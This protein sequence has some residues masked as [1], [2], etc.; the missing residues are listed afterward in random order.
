LHSISA[1]SVVLPSVCL[2]YVIRY[3]TKR[4]FQEINV[5]FLLQ[6]LSILCT[7]ASLYA[8]Y[9]LL[10]ISNK[11]WMGEGGE[12]VGEKRGGRVGGGE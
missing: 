5:D 7:G 10:L 2:L 8:P 6:Y 3:R 9:S 12:S 11:F 1:F 4:D